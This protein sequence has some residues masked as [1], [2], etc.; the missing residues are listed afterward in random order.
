MLCISVSIAVAPEF[1]Y[2]QR[3]ITSEHKNE[4]LHSRLNGLLKTAS[5]GKLGGL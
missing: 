1:Y 2:F 3:Q 5:S 4:M